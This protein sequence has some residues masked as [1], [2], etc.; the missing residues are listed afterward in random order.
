MNPRR[1]AAARWDGADLI[2]Q[3]RVQPR[4][5]RDRIGEPEAGSLRI[6]LTAAPVGGAANTR[7]LQVLAKAF[8]VARSRIRIEAGLASRD[9]RVRIQ[10]PRRTPPGIPPAA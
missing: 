10:S 4:A 7:L 3:V 1:G 8:G 9:K 2:L 5:S 6:S